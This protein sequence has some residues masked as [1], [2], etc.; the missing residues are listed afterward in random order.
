[1]SNFPEGLSQ[2]GAVNQ[3]LVDIETATITIVTPAGVDP[4][5]EEVVA[6]R[7]ISVVSLTDTRDISWRGFEI[8]HSDWQGQKKGA[9]PAKDG[10]SANASGLIEV[11]NSH[12]VSIASCELAHLGGWALGIT[13][14]SRA[15]T[16]TQSRVFDS[17]TGGVYMDQCG[18]GGGGNHS[19]NHNLLSDGGHV[20]PQGV[21]V[22]VSCAPNNTISYNEITGFHG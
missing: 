8:H 16:L 1:M 5:Q 2:P 6:G 10:S 4:T 14:S 12:N 20:I 19:I 13:G 9:W 15:V 3:F 11:H 18:G 22:H 21:G 17:A 7:L